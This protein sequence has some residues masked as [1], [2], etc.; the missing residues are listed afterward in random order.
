MLS[1]QLRLAFGVGWGRQESRRPAAGPF[2][3]QA[4]AVPLL[5]LSAGLVL[6]S[7]GL[8]GTL[9]LGPRST[10]HTPQPRVRHTSLP[11]R[12]PPVKLFVAAQQQ[13][14]R[15]HRQP[16]GAMVQVLSGSLSKVVTLSSYLSSH[17][18]GGFFVWGLFFFVCLLI[19]FWRMQILG[20][21]VTENHSPW[22]QGRNEE[23]LTSLNTLKS[24]WDER[25]HEQARLPGERAQGR[26]TFRQSSWCWSQGSCLRPRAQ[27]PQLHPTLT[28][29]K[30]AV[31]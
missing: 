6:G 10:R 30:V 3:G 23:V 28:T 27:R 11:D 26:P 5:P 15:G 22:S 14:W 25:T 31:L 4:W 16:V 21:L 2:E 18:C 9:A 17:S 13:A 1:N 12:A 8:G 19:L 7:S 29:Q 20:H 24:G